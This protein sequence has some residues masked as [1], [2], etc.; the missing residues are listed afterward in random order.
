MTLPK[1]RRDKTSRSCFML[2]VQHLNMK[3]LISMG[4]RM[5][6]EERLPDLLFIQVPGNCFL[7][8]IPGRGD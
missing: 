6:C 8:S 3:V 1:I 4:E 5:D 2:V 7:L